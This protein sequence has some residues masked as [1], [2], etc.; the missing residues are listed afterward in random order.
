[1]GPKDLHVPSSAQTISRIHSAHERDVQ[2]KDKPTRMPVC[3]CAVS[4]EG[5]RRASPPP[6]PAPGRPRDRMPGINR[7]HLCVAAFGPSTGTGIGTHAGLVLIKQSN[8]CT[9]PATKALISPRGM[10]LHC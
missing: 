1:M 7:R 6:M 3:L 10:L 2:A 8:V 4:W 5:V 9:H